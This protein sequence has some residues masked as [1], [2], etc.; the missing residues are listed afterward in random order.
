VAL[1]FLQWS[2]DPQRRFALISID[3]TPTQRV[4]EGD[5]A[6]G[7]TVTEITPTGVQFKREGQVF[8]IRPRH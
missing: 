5:S 4:R 3:G 7:L 6:S 2:A 8:M 1:T